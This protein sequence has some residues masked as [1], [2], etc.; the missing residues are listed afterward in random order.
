MP[1]TKL[2]LF[3]SAELAIDAE[4]NNKSISLDWLGM[5]SVVR[6]ILRN[7]IKEEP[8]DDLNR[9]QLQAIIYK[10]DDAVAAFTKRGTVYPNENLPRR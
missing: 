2:G 10:I 3:E 8:M 5:E 7:A 4:W 1:R 9:D 6:E